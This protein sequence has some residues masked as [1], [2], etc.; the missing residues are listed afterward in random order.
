MTTVG[1]VRKKPQTRRAHY[2][3]YTGFQLHEKSAPLTPLLFKDQLYLS[4]NKAYS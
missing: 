4:L 3:L 1:C 2:K